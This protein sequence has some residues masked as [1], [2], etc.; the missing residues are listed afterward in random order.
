MLAGGRAAGR[1]G[2]VG[3]PGILYNSL[4]HPGHLEKKSWSLRAKEE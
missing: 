4:A 2:G 3:E 1:L